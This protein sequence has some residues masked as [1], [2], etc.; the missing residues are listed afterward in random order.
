MGGEAVGCPGCGT[1]ATRKNGRDRQARQV[2]QC[3]DCHQRF[4]ARSARPFSGYRFPPEVITLAVRW[5]TRYRLRYADV[6]ELLAE[7]GIGV[8]A[9]TVYDWVREFAPLYEGAARSL[10]ASGMGPRRRRMGAGADPKRTASLVRRR[11][12][13]P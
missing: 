11:P 4:T 6:D 8:A 9:S 1:S 12:A 5:Y 13:R 7:R 10:V 2:H 3:L